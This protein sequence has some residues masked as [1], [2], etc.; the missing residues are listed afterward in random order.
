[1]Q[2]GVLRW[3]GA[4]LNSQLVAGGYS[5]GNPD[6]NLN[7][8]CP[9]VPS[10]LWS[11][12]VYAAKASGSASARAQLVG[13]AADGVTVVATVSG[14][15]VALTTTPTR[16]SV[17]ANPGDLAASA[18]VVLVVQSLTASAPNLLLSCTLLVDNQLPDFW[19]VGAGVPRVVWP[20][21]PSRAVGWHLGSD[22]TVT[23]AEC[24]S[25]AS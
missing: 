17:S 12:F 21:S 6:A 20:T 18:F 24:Y 16:L 11:G 13:I 5:G 4:G 19:S 10:R 1:M 3:S 25:G 22:L 2:S 8:G 9:Y 23:F 7:Y 14:P 15:T